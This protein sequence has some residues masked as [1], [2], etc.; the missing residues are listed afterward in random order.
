MRLLAGEP[1]QSTVEWWSRCASVVA[2][3]LAMVVVLSAGAVATADRGEAKRQ[4][5]RAVVL[6]REDR[7]TDVFIRLSRDVLRD[8]PI[9]VEWIEPA[10]PAGQSVLPPGLTSLPDPGWAAVSPALDELADEEPGVAALYPRRVVVNDAGIGA[11]TE[12]VAY[13][14][15]SAGRSLGG[16]QDALRIRGQDVVGDPVT[17]RVAGFGGAGGLPV[18]ADEPSRS[19]TVPVVA[20]LVGGMAASVL[21]WLAV[22]I[23]RRGRR[24]EPRSADV[25]ARS[26]PALTPQVLAAGFGIFVGSVIW[27]ELC[28]RSRCIPLT[29]VSDLQG[30]HHLRLLVGSCALVGGAFAAISVLLG[31]VQRLRPR[32]RPSGPRTWG[33]VGPARLVPLF[34]SAGLFVVS[35]LTSLPLVPIATACAVVG[36]FTALPLVVAR[37][38]RNLAASPREIPASVGRVIR[39]GPVVAAAP[40]GALLVVLILAIIS[41]PSDSAPPTVLAGGTAGARGQPVVGVQWFDVERG[42]VV[43]LSER[44]GPDAVVV[45]FGRSSDGQRSVEGRRGSGTVLVGAT[46]DQ[47]R[48]V[49]RVNCRST[50]G[51]LVAEEGGA[52]LVRLLS[53]VSEESP[54][55]VEL[56]APRTLPATGQVLVFGTDALSLDEAVQ[57][58]ARSALPAALVSS[59]TLEVT[60]DQRVLSSVVLALLAILGVA[61]LVLAVDRS[62]RER[63]ALAA[64]SLPRGSLRRSTVLR[65]TVC[66]WT[67]GA[68]GVVVGYVVRLQTLVLAQDDTLWSGLGAVV[69]ALAVGSLLGAGALVVF[70]PAGPPR[71]GDAVEP[72]VGQTAKPGL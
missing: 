61:A 70:G 24:R 14:R 16:E 41:F 64:S 3:A 69:V 9:R 33:S 27:L 51:P 22:S 25:G 17:V 11:S 31:R 66:W 29:S 42:D 38:G 63:D 5:G 20:A 58:V 56:V 47:L 43:A 68:V 67:A 35:A 28:R 40:F 62:I 19:W 23:A 39:D 2:T 49:L 52:E 6:S 18:F 26:R 37:V 71:I 34:L 55:R 59:P 57:Q 1:E 7:P 48:R 36:G 30:A 12:L 32:A 8:Q 13:L 45:P 65:F 4:A 72:Q 15:P 50:L 44:L 21:L 46:C 10:G 60:S 54:R 53:S